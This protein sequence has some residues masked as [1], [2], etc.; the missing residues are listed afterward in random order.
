M[1]ATAILTAAELV[2]TTGPSLLA[3]CLNW[4]LYGVM[5]VQAYHY[6]ASFTRRDNRII[7]S[8]VLVLFLLDTTQTAMITADAFH[9]FVAGY[10]NAQMLD[11]IWINGIDVPFLDA[12]I[13]FIAQAFYCWRIWFLRDGRR[14]K[15]AIP[16]LILLVATMQFA[17]G[18]VVGI[19]AQQVARWSLIGS[20]FVETTIWFTGAAVADLSIAIVMSWTLLYEHR[21]SVLSTNSVISRVVRLI[22]ETNAITATFAVLALIFY[23]GIPSKPSMVVPVTS[24]IGKL[25]TNSL[26]AVLNNRGKSHPQSVFA[27]PETLRMPTFSATRN[28]SGSTQTHDDSLELGFGGVHGMRFGSGDRSVDKHPQIGEES[29]DVVGV[30]LTNERGEVV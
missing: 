5:C 7:K 28:I 23:W 25:Y 9:W 4:W 27:A 2:W 15:N 19:K 12:L 6:T 1:S 8:L 29:G 17:A 21:S 11:E 14:W 3:T 22:A 18:M 20:E 10:G 24:C 30:K 16:G 13:A 26:V